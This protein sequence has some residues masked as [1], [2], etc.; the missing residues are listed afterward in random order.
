MCVCVC[1]CVCSLGPTSLGRVEGILDQHASDER[2][3]SCSCR[4]TLVERVNGRVPLCEH[5]QRRRRHRKRSRQNVLERSRESV[6][7]RQL[8]HCLRKRREHS[9][10]C[11]RNLSRGRVDGQWICTEQR[12]QRL[13]VGGRRRRRHSVRV[14]AAAGDDGGGRG[15]ASKR[16]ARVVHIGRARVCRR[17]R[18]CY[19]VARVLEAALALRRATTA[20]GARSRRVVS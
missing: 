6:S 12:Q 10:R 8:P 18:D 14:V 4:S 1:V 9:Q 19:G 16:R 5:G 11:W 3:R 2:L 20:V 13:R 7:E 15:G 17:C